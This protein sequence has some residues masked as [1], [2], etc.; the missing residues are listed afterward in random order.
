ML[1]V[2]DE[3]YFSGRQMDRRI[4]VIIRL[5]QLLDVV[6]V[7]ALAELGNKINVSTL[8]NILC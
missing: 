8:Y 1:N 7:E 4:E 5:S 3:V 6:V 2:E